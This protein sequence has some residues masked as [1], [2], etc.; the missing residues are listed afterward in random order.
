MEGMIEKAQQSDLAEILCV[1]KAA[2]STIAAFLKIPTL[3][4]MTQTLE[5][6]QDEY[7]SWIFLKYTLNGH[8]VG[9]VRAIIDHDHICHI[10]KLVVLPEYQNAGIGKA[11][12]HDVHERFKSSKTFQLFTGKNVNHI[13]DFYHKLGYAQM[14]TKTMNGIIMVFMERNN[15]SVNC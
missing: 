14:Y 1:Q 5:E 9:S 12:M 6:I 2:F 7:D 8:I 10:G 11:L 4:P 3:Q 15:D 13:V